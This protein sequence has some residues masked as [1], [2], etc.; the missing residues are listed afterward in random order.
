MM[1]MMMMM[2][3]MTIRSVDL[4]TRNSKTKKYR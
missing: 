3:M 1:I 2:M 4:I